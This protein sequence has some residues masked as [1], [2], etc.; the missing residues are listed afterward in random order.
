MLFFRWAYGVSLSGF[1]GIGVS[2]SGIIQFIFNIKFKVKL[3]L[4]GQTKFE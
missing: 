4:I 2:D 1:D 3:I